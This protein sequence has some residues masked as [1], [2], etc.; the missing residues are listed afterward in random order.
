MRRLGERL[1]YYLVFAFC[2][3]PRFCETAEGQVPV[4]AQ[5]SLRASVRPND[6]VKVNPSLPWVSE[7]DAPAIYTEWWKEIAACEHL[8]LPV[9]LEQ[10]VH[11]VQVN[12]NSFHVGPEDPNSTWGLTD[13]AKLTIYVAQG[14][15]GDREVIT[16][17][18]VHQ[19]DYWQ[20]VDQGEDW[21]LSDQFDK[22]CGLHTHHP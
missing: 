18:M 17:E 7:Y 13:A 11:W 9:E 6:S 20:G 14:S 1:W 2:V 15:V 19:L 3:L 21:H 8:I 4:F 22:V 10:A 12:A 16:H 5:H